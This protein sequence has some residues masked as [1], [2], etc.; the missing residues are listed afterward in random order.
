MSDNS[1]YFGKKLVL[2]FLDFLRYKIETDGLTVDEVEAL[3]KTL[4]KG[5][6]LSGT[7]QDF[8]RFYERS[9]DNV[10]VVLSRKMLSPPTRKVL[11]SF[12]AFR[13]VVPASWRQ[14]FQ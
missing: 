9:K 10:N 5:L 8:A 7:A 11:Y 2:E 14:K 4:E 13:K 3:A 1:Q 6:P 12:N